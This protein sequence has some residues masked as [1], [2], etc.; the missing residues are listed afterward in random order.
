MFVRFVVGADD[1]S[2]LSLTGI[3]NAAKQPRDAEVLS[4]EEEE[5]LDRCYGWLNEHLPVPPF[6]TA[7]WS[8]DAVAWFRDD[9]TEAIR[10]MWDIVAILREHEISV[11]MLRSRNPGRV[12]YED[13]YQV[14]V[15]E[16]NRL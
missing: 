4:V 7:G 5:R 11:R 14:V 12:L 15:E 13:D 6:K 16:W 10:H 9:A 8:R 3:I 2:H 1:D